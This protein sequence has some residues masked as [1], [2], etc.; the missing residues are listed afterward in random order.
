MP[1]TPV[2][3]A[4]LTWYQRRLLRRLMRQAAAADLPARKYIRDY[5]ERTRKRAAIMAY[6][7]GGLGLLLGSALLAKA[8]WWAS[9]V[10]QREMVKRLGDVDEGVD[11]V[12]AATTNVDRTLA[13]MA[14]ETDRIQRLAIK[15]RIAT[16]LLGAVL[17]GF[18][19]AF[20]A[21][22]IGSG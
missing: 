10:F 7:G 6:G 20:A 9:T 21:K 4:D 19:G 11:Q 18:A 22:I 3:V 13:Q 16:G 14:T 8:L 5:L 15:V 1:D 17:G 12:H 2:T